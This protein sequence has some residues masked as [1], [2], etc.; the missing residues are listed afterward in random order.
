MSATEAAGRST[1]NLGALE[2]QVMQALWDQG[3]QTVRE[4]IDYLSSDHA[5][6][7]IATVLGN[8]RRKGLVDA[9][10][11]NHKTQYVA[12]LSRHEHAARLMDHAL[13]ASN[14]R[15]GSILHF[16]GSMPDDDLALLRGYLLSRDQADPS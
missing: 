15:A 9:V 3:P 8:L 5:Y 2:A 11:E 10:R 16:V 14:D 1:L 13:E 12:S 4:V 7:T 6:T